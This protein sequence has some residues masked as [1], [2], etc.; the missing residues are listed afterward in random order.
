MRGPQCDADPEAGIRANALGTFHILEAARLFGVRQVIFAGSQ[1]I[2]SA[3][4]PMD[5]GLHD[6]TTT[7]PETIYATAKLFSENVGLCYRRLYDI[8]FRGP[9]LATVLGP[10]AE[11]QG[12]LEYST[13]PSKKA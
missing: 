2:F 7:R 8:D 3:A 9:R 4:H 11:T 1:S 10:G 13:N 12:Y 6:Y 5:K